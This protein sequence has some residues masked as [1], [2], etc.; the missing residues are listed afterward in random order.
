VTWSERVRAA[1]ERD[2]G[3][4]LVEVVIA[5]VLLGILSAA[6]LAVV[7]QTQSAGV[8]NRNRIAAANLAAREIDMVR[9]EFR[10]TSGAPLEIAA[11]GTAV[12]ARP[13][14]TTAAGQ[15]LVVDGTPYTVTTSVQWNITGGGE[16][17]CDGG[18]LVIYPTLGVTVT[19]T[20]PN[21][22]A[23]QPV[24]SSTALAPEKGTGIP[25]TDSF[26]AVKVTDAA[27]AANSGRGVTVTGGGA[28]RSGTTDAQGCAVVQVSPAAGIGTDY[29]ARITD[30]GYVD[31]AGTAN[32]SKVVGLIGQGQLNNNV[33]FQVDKA[34]S[35]ALRL[36]D[37]SGVP[38]A[39]SAAGAQITLVASESSGA[40]NQRTVTATGPVTT[41]GGL[42]PTRYG[43]YFGTTA[44]AAGF[45]YHQ[46]TPGSTATIDVTYAAAR[47]VLTALP[48]GTT[49]VFAGPVGT[50]SCTGPEV[51]PVD[52]GAVSLLP[53]TWSFFAS[54]PSF[55]C[56][57]GPT[58]IVL[59]SGDNGE[60]MW[61]QTT[62]RVDNAPAGVLWAVNRT[63]SG[64]LTTCANGAAAAT[65]VN[66]DG[67]RAGGVPIAAGDWFVYVTDGA[68]GGGCVGTP[69]GQYS[70]VLNYDAENVLTWT[71]APVPSKVTARN[72]GSGSRYTV[73]AWTGAQQ[74]S[75]T[76]S[77]PAGVTTLSKPSNTAT[78]ATGTFDVGTWR[79]FIRDTNR[80]SCTFAGTVVVDGSGKAFDLALNTS[81]PPTM[82]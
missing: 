23:I 44:P 71:N 22:G 11:A 32:P 14:G 7:L 28:S 51:R 47:W 62:L 41:V 45:A 74:M 81:N 35:V 76:R 53:G 18:S 3:A 6:V 68:A 1:R 54:G 2:S 39:A 46:L 25:D 13:L 79:F 61:G 58:G 36:V 4:S 70:K 15:P 72:F 26:V 82:R 56:S 38:L 67:A 20:W 66:V 9:A 52:P 48:E 24:V 34:G 19:V 55:D 78:T 40:T 57:T 5:C 73:V 27:G 29:T 80:S 10:E 65:A 30:S 37:E 21:M 42:W 69:F 77:L 43:A 59:G 17:A 8:N 31:I 49:S 60:E 33:T 12:N 75:C 50:A 63:R 16:S 64:N